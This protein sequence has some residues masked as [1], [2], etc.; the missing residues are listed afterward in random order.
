MTARSLTVYF[1]TI[2]QSSLHSKPR[3]NRRRRARQSIIL[4]LFVFF[5]KTPVSGF[6]LLGNEACG[7]SSAPSTP[8]RRYRPNPSPGRPCHRRFVI[9][10]RPALPAATERLLTP[11][12]SLRR[13]SQQPRNDD[14][15][16]LN[17]GQ[18][19]FWAKPVMLKRRHGSTH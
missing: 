4:F 3:T 5:R 11:T 17:V 12:I 13:P 9:D 16:R 18:R 7:V 2:I 6:L 19:P 10:R 14:E 15:S 1:R 8:H